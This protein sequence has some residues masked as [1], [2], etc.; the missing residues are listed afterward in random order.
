M[1]LHEAREIMAKKLEELAAP[2]KEKGLE[3]VTR[4]LYTDRTL[5]EY[6]EFNE[7]CILIFGDI[8]IG[9]E[10]LDRDDYCN[11]SMCCEVKTA[12]VNDAELEKEINN[13]DG[14]LA[15]FMEKLEKSGK[16]PTALI[17]EINKKQEEDAEEAAKQFSKEMNKLRLKLLISIGIIVV[18]LLAVLIGIPLLT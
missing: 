10:D 11:Y 5:Q 1:N 14:E 8:A 6:S 13:L 9:T 7:K 16:T 17:S 3:V 12:L 4:V 15:A 18:I 2:I